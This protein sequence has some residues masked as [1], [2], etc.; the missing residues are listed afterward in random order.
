MNND[1]VTIYLITFNRKDKLSRAVTSIL[2]QTY[3]DIE[4]IV[5]DNG[6]NDGTEDMMEHVSLENE[7]VNYIRLDR[8]YGACFA[9]NKAIEAANGYYI[10]GSDDDDYFH[11][12]RVRVLLDKYKSQHCSSSFSDD[13]FTVEENVKHTSNKPKIVKFEQICFQNYIGNQ[14]FTETQKIRDLGGFDESLPAAQDYDMWFRLIKKY[15]VSVKTDT[16]L[17]YIDLDGDDRITISS[18]KFKGYMLF[19][20]KHKLD[21]NINQRKHQLL[22][23][24]YA[25][26]NKIPFGVFLI[27]FN[28]HNIKRKIKVFLT[29]VLGNK[30]FDF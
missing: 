1:L 17:Q 3:K 27:L 10:T 2:N 30:E 4:I 7:C 15:G 14:I 12:D 25:T 8:N 13:I 9:R 5:V 11:R 16:P 28:T 18:K 23:I 29:K 19:Y 22:N 6:S 20:K 21:L 26:R 24:K